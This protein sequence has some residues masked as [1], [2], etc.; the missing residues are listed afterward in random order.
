MRSRTLALAAL[1]VACGA[2]DREGSAGDGEPPRIVM[3]THGQTAD[4]FWSVVANGARAAADEVGA[5]FEYQAP[6]RFDMA[7]MSD[8]IEAAAASRPAALVVSLPDAEALGHAVRRAVESG[9]PV[10][11]INSGSEASAGLG[12]LAHVGQTELEAGVAAGRRLAEAGGRGLLCVNHEVGNLALDLRCEG[13]AEGMA[14]RGGTARVLAVDLADPDDTQ[15]RIGAAL[16]RDPALDAVL[17]LGPAAAGP[18]LA[19]IRGAGRADVRYAT[20]DLTPEVLQAIERGDALFAVDQQPWLQGWLP[21]AMLA[22][23]LETLTVPG[24]GEVIRTGPHL[25]TA[26]TAA[27]VA[28]LV[29]RGV[30]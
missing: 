16:A 5:D 10:V 30:R 8:L 4:P 15:Q 9:V 12:A 25:V 27:R 29:R 21:V 28:E 11:T 7:A 23:W 20:F 2:G 19:A 6:P 22:N 3:I 18:A 1:L 17:T 26:E 14:Q 13:A 24:G